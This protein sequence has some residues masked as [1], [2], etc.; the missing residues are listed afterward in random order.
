MCEPCT[1][2]TFAFALTP[3]PRFQDI[4]DP[5]SAGIDQRAGLNCAARAA[6]GVFDSDAPNAVGL[7]DLDRARTGVDFGAA[8]RRI[9]RG[10]HHQ[11]RVIDKAVGIFECPGEAVR[12]QGPSDLVPGQVDRTGR[13]QQVATADMVVKEQ[14][15]PQQPGRPQPGMMR[16]NET[17]R[18]DDVGGDLP[19]DFALDQRLAHQPELV[20]FEVAQPAMHQLGRPRRRPARQIIHFTKENGISPARRIARDA[21]AIDAAADNSEVENPVQWRFPGRSPVRFGD[22]AFGLE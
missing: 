18:S 12:H 1:S 13:R 19:E 11:P 22:F 4:L 5:W 6:R 16:Q 17:K 7:A 8:I 15:E 20:I 10:E 3:A 9:P 2:R 14:P 21:A